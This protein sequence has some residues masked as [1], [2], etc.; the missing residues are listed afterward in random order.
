MRKWPQTTV[1]VLEEKTEIAAAKSDWRVASSQDLNRYT[2]MN[3]APEVMRT[4][5]IHTS[6]KL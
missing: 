1:I 4:E 2:S 3:Q 5:K 6:I